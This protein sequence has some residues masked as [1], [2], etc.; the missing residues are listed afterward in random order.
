M[1]VSIRV[2]DVTLNV[3]LFELLKGYLCNNYPELLGKSL[4][5]KVVHPKPYNN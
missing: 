1:N 5:L 2:K 4:P 3:K